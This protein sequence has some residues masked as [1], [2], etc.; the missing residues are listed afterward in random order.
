MVRIWII[1]I[2]LALALAMPATAQQ[3][4]APQILERLHAL[5]DQDYK[6][7]CIKLGFVIGRLQPGGSSEI[8][9]R[10]P[11]MVVVGAV[12]A[13]TRARAVP[14][15]YRL[16]SEPASVIQARL[17]FQNSGPVNSNAS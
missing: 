9:A 10:S 1:G 15:I 2:A 16:P 4:S 11:G 14:V 17:T 3:R 12:V 8:A 7:A 6:P 5:C 13:P